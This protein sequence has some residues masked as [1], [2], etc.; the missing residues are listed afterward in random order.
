MGW[1]HSAD[2]S[3]NLSFEL[4]GGIVLLFGC[5]LIN[6]R[7]LW[8]YFPADLF[9]N[10]DHFLCNTMITS[11]WWTDTFSIIKQNYLHPDDVSYP[12]VCLLHL[13]I[14]AGNPNG[15]VRYVNFGSQFT[16]HQP[17]SQIKR[18]D[19]H[20]VE[21]IQLDS[22][23]IC[24][25]SRRVCIN[26]GR[27]LLKAWV[28]LPLSVPSWTYITN[29]GLFLYRQY[30]RGRLPSKEYQTLPLVFGTIFNSFNYF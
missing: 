2:C 8:R 23:M 22:L 17:E 4:L 7:I 30:H 16:E 6:T 25:K 24:N 14:Q 11:K 12:L 28:C 19:R 9:T 15:E 20:N 10:I 26:I 13:N 5:H 3:A 27:E 21:N 29:D 1:W 18:I